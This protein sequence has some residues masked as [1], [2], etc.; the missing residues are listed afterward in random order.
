MRVLRPPPGRPALVALGP[1]VVVGM[2]GHRCPGGC[3]QFIPQ[4]QYACRGCWYRLP[5]DLRRPITSNYQRN[6]RAHRE[7]MVDARRWFGEN[8]LPAGPSA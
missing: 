6:P 7:A 1:G 8:P 3:T 4:H 2:S 5:V